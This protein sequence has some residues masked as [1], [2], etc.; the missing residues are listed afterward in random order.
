MINCNRLSMWSYAKDELLCLV[1][2]MCVETV[3]YSILVNNNVA[4]HITPN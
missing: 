2:L 3:N 4:E 1:N